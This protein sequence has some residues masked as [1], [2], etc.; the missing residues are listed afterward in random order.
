MNVDFYTFSKRINSTAQPT[1]GASYSCVLKSPSSVI[2]PKISIVWGGSGNPSAYNYAYIGDYG[3][4]YWVSNWT[5]ADRQWHADLSVDVLATYKTEIGASSKYILRAASD[6]NTNVIDKAYP[7]KLPTKYNHTNYSTGWAQNMS[8][9]TFVVGIIGKGNT[10]SAGGISLYQA[11]ASQVQT[12]INN[13]YNAMDGIISA[14]TGHTGSPTTSEQGFGWLNDAVFFLADA[15]IRCTGKVSDFIRSVMWF[16]FSFK[17]TGTVTVTMGLV[18]SGTGSANNITDPLYQSGAIDLATPGMPI[19]AVEWQYVEPFYEY[20]LS[21]PPFGIIPISAK[22]LYK[23]STIR[24][25]VRADAVSGAGYLRVYANSSGIVDDWTLLAERSAQLGVQIPI[26][27]N[28]QNLLQF[29]SGIVGAYQA[30]SAENVAGMLANIGSAV[31]GGTG[32]SRATGGSG[33]LAAITG[34]ASLHWRYTEPVDEDITEQG[35]PLCEVRQISNLS[36][37]VQCRDGDISAPGT[38][39]ELAQLE[40]FLTGGFFYE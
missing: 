32:T 33:G 18:T 40:S 29:A 8:G 6:Y 27:G 23:A 28:N 3:R 5:Y 39:S 16:P 19:G 36:G 21:F 2:S 15:I 25:T 17:T 30:A 24:C 14:G 37:F 13:A 22:D 20:W 1:G 10:Y 34:T 38:A 35:R 7:A 9:G 11:S 31:D 4:Y 12:I 26:G